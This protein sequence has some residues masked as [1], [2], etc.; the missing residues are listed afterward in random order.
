MVISKPTPAVTESGS[1][2]KW[3]TGPPAM[4]IV[5]VVPDPALEAAPAAA[6]VHTDPGFSAAWAWEPVSARSPAEPGTGLSLPSKAVPVK[7]KGAPA[8]EV[9]GARM[10]KRVAAAMLAT[11]GPLFPGMLEDAV[12]VAVRLRVVRVLGVA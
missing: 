10:P 5:S 1:T 2:P 6:I 9:A 3:V 12:S 11:M 4:G 8:P 7:L